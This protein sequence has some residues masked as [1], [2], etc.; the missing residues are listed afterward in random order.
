MLYAMAATTLAGLSTGL[1]GLLGVLRRPGRRGMAF[2]LGFGAGVMIT[3]SLAD[4]LPEAM[5]RYRAAFSPAGAA[6]AA[7]SLA[8]LGMAA[9]LLL[10][11][12]V[13]E[14]RL[15]AGR[16]EEARVLHSA[17]VTALAL[18]AHNLP[19][20]VL[21]LFSGLEDPTLGLRLA[22]AVALH[23]LPE[24]LAVALPV[25]Y[26]T[27]SRAKGA[28]AALV[29]GLAEPAGALAAFALLGGRLTAG[30]VTGL[31]ALVSGVMCWVSVA[32]LLPT[33]FSLGRRGDTAAGFGAGL[34]AMTLGIG[35]LS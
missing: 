27:R 15:F 20:G 12:L 9:A 30:L 7:A 25:Y 6:G 8:A 21:T 16:G 5:E 11:R 32:E 34:L 17:L 26:A 35:L 31:V 33:G 2:S 24:G 13:P 22:V 29:S 23:N 3:V 1:G 4:M 28:A 18:V 14:P 10:G 19:E